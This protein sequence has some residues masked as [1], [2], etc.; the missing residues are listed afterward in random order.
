MILS[1]Q[2]KLSNYL[3]EQISLIAMQIKLEELVVEN[4]KDD[5]N[6]GSSIKSKDVSSVL[7]IFLRKHSEFLWDFLNQKYGNKNK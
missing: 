1:D 6:F 4:G 7:P 2:E 5:E 3:S